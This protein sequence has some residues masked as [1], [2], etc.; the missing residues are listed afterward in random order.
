MSK[1]TDKLC[2]MVEDKL[3][4]LSDQA[5][6]DACDEFSSWF[7]SSAEAKRDQMEKAS[8]AAEMDDEVTT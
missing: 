6:I 2:G 7:D 5:Y 4:D 8:D 1:L 3:V